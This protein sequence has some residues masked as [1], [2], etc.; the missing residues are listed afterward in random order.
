MP[1]GRMGLGDSVSI[2]VTRSRKQKRSFVRRVRDW[3]RLKA[4]VPV[5]EVRK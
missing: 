3:F 5:K 1:I 2:K 4:K